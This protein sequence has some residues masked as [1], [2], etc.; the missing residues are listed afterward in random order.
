MGQSYNFCQVTLAFSISKILNKIWGII[1]RNAIL[2]ADSDNK[3]RRKPWKIN[4]FGGVF[5]VAKRIWTSDLPLRSM[6]YHLVRHTVT[7]L[8]ILKKPWNYGIFQR[9]TFQ[10]VLA[11]SKAF[12]LILN[13]PIS[14]LLAKVFQP[15]VLY[16]FSHEDNL[17]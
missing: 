7:W 6:A 10:I 8:P 12:R 13:R 15:L 11:H 14:K 2:L 9:F 4:V 1:S 17:I 3:K 16:V 5:G